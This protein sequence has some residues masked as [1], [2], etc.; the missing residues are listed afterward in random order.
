MGGVG[1]PKC[2]TCGV[3]EWRHLCS[4][5]GVVIAGVRLDADGEPLEDE[6]VEVP[7]ALLDSIEAI[8]LKAKR[9]RPRVIGDMKA[10]KAEK[11]REYRAKERKE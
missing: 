11:A 6:T 2:E 8:A 5:D 3:A 10:Y 9:G 1:P 4:R 7:L